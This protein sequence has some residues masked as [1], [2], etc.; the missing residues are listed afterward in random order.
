MAWTGCMRPVEVGPTPGR[1]GVILPYM[2]SLPY[3]SGQNWQRL[4]WANG[5]ER[6]FFC[7]R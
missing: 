5:H 7:G 6:R 3:S 2:V 1:G 4:S